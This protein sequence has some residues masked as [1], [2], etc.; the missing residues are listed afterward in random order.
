M[1]IVSDDLVDGSCTDLLADEAQFSTML[2]NGIF[3]D[4]FLLAIPVSVDPAGLV[5]P[6]LERGVRERLS[7]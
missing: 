1:A 3:K 7:R 2:L 4:S 5:L 6:P